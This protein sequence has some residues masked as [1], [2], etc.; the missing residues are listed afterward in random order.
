MQVVSGTNHILVVEA[1]DDAGPKTLEVTVWEKLSCNVKENDAAMELTHFK[2]VGPAAEV[3]RAGYESSASSD[4]LASSSKRKGLAQKCLACPQQQ[5]QHWLVH[6]CKYRLERHRHMPLVLLHLRAHILFLPA[7]HG[8]AAFSAL[9]CVHASPSVSHCS[10]ALLL[11]PFP[12][13]LPPCSA[14][15]PCL[16]Y[17]RCAPLQ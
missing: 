11:L 5:Q 4:S 17:I 1:A 16:C 2:L 6:A 13:T 9:L 7:A 15:L 10:P 14:A 8:P 12:C 3:C